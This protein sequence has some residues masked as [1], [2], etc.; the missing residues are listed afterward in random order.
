MFKPSG[1]LKAI[2]HRLFS[3]AFYFFCCVSLALLPCF[4][5]AIQLDNLRGTRYCE[6]VFTETPEVLAIY[7]SIGLND[8]PEKIWNKISED[9][10]KQQTGA[11]FVKL[12]GPR[13][14]VI[15][16]MNNF[17]LVSNVPKTISGLNMRK[18]AMVQLD[19]S[20]EIAAPEPY[21]AHVINRETTWLYKAGKPIYELIDPQG[22]VYVMQSYSTQKS[23]Q[24]TDSLNELESRL[25]LPSGWHF[26]TGILQQDK[27]LSSNN[28]QA[29]VVQ[30][31]FQNTY[32]LAPSDFL[33]Q[34]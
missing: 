19:P 23:I 5:Q 16:S 4:A 29:T 32:Q 26:R 31:D 30:D 24:T 25:T 9:S 18:A 11:R 8:C 21:Q 2:P 27:T 6:I 1:I 28:N 33:E 12:N 3:Q 20:V 14:W 13:Y 7:S 17:T 15:D 22:Q 34:S 10:V